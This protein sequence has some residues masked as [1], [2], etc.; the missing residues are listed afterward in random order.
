MLRFELLIY[1]QLIGILLILG[2]YELKLLK[3]PPTEINND[4]DINH[5]ADIIKYNNSETG[6]KY[7]IE[8][9]IGLSVVIHFWRLINNRTIIDL[10]IALVSV[11]FA[12]WYW[13]ELLPLERMFSLND[14]MFFNSLVSHHIV[15]G[16]FVWTLFSFTLLAS[17]LN[18]IWEP[19]ELIFLHVIGGILMIDLTIDLPLLINP[20]A[21]L[22]LHYGHITNAVGTATL[23][24]VIPG[25]I[26]V[27]GL[28]MFYRLYQKSFI[29][30]FLFILFAAGGFLFATQMAPLEIEL[31]HLGPN[32]SKQLKIAYSH[33]ITLIL[34]VFY[35]SFKLTYYYGILNKIS[36]LSKIPQT[37]IEQPKENLQHQ[38]VAAKNPSPGPSKPKTDKK[39]KLQ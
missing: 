13:T 34:V 4:P 17:G 10:S 9:L 8:F 14:Q 23:D 30:F 24:L 38:N 18:Y 16:L 22:S 36:K 1:A 15:F 32:S 11:P 27:F 2:T 12:L 7:Y 26:V 25:I 29:D 20:K 6:I 33:F 37:T 39:K 5:F 21:P 3:I 28:M 19:V 31:Y 35:T